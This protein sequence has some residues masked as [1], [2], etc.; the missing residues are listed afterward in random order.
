MQKSVTLPNHWEFL[1]FNSS[2]KFYKTRMQNISSRFCS[3]DISSESSV[4][5]HRYHL[6]NR[7]NETA[8]YSTKNSSEC[9]NRHDVE[10]S[11]ITFPLKTIIE[12]SKQNLKHFFTQT[13]FQRSSFEDE[14]S[15]NPVIPLQLY[16]L[17]EH[18]F[19]Q[20]LKNLLSK[21]TKHSDPEH[22]EVRSS[23]KSQWD[24]EINFP[25]LRKMRKIQWFEHR[26]VTCCNLKL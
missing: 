21:H 24:G 10:R 9:S 13:N 20:C 16:P 17:L 7:H 5:I 11:L 12:N 25:L 8:N 2:Q 14:W 22:I 15:G 18:I 3:N 26:L 4:C 19:V 23:S 1:N 6:Y